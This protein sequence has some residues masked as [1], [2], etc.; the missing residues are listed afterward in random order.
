MAR[1]RVGTGGLALRRRRAGARPVRTDDV[2]QLASLGRADAFL[3]EVGALADVLV[4]AIKALLTVAQHGKVAAHPLARAD[5][6]VRER[7]AGA[8]AAAGVLEVDA[9]RGALWCRV[10]RERAC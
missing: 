2:R 1:R 6:D 7:T 3:G 8:V 10:V 9:Q 4:L 5:P